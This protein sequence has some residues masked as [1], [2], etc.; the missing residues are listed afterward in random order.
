MKIVERIKVSIKE[1]GGLFVIEG[2][3]QIMIALEDGGG[4]LRDIRVVGA[5]DQRGG[6]GELAGEL[7]SVLRGGGGN[8]QR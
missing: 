6:V 3:P 4:G 8:G 5:G 2:L 7:K 1:L